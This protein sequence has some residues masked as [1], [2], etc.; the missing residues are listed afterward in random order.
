[1]FEDS[2]PGLSF[3]VTLLEALLQHPSLFVEK[4]R[5]WVRNAPKHIPF[6]DPVRGMVLVHVLV[7]QSQPAND[8]TPLIREQRIVNTVRLGKLREYRNRVVADGKDRDPV[9]REVG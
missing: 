3:S 8:L 9:A 5:A 7:E 2:S 4:E 6:R 1:M